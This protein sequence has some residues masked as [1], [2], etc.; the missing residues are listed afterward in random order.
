MPVRTAVVTHTAI[1]T[2]ELGRKYTWLDK[3]PV[4]FPSLPVH[5]GYCPKP[6]PGPVTICLVS[7]SDDDCL[8][9][10][11]CCLLSCGAGCLEPVQGNVS[12][13][14]QPSTEPCARSQGPPATLRL[15]P[16]TCSE[17]S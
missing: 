8:G 13:P 15:H 2:P 3:F 12:W 14:W 7:C 4:L 1:H 6:D 11:K 17:R 5:P 10:E 16:Q 9:S